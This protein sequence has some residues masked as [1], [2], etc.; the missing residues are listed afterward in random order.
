MSLRDVTF[1]N[2]SNTIFVLDMA[3]VI[4]IKSNIEAFLDDSSAPVE[5]PVGYSVHSVPKENSLVHFRLEFSK[6]ILF[7]EHKTP[8]SEDV[9]KLDVGIFVVVKPFVKCFGSSLVDD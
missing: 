3:K 1:Q 4:V 2:K 6:V 5:N 9:E 7:V 8:T